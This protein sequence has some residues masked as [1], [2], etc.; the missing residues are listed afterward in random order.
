MFRIFF[1]SHGEQAFGALP[2]DMQ[3]RINDVLG[4]LAGDPLW[5]HRVKKLGGSE[6]RYRLRIG[7]WR[8]LLKRRNSEFEVMDIFLKT[9]EQDYRRRQ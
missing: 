8:I 3:G 7:R 4:R 1:S 2:K 6:D 9:G 5:H